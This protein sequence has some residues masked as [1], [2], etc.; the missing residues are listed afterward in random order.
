M[1]LR[2]CQFGQLVVVYSGNMIKPEFH[3][4]MTQLCDL[5]SQIG[6]CCLIY[7]GCHFVFPS[8]EQMAQ[9]TDYRVFA[10][11]LILFFKYSFGVRVL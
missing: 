1:M 8:I 2:F 3:K 11:S 7:T 5:F 10:D 9:A 6:E 4:V